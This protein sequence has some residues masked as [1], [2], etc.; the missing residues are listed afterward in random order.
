M[1]SQI[2][3][4]GRR[5]MLSCNGRITSGYCAGTVRVANADDRCVRHARRLRCLGMRSYS[6]A[7]WRDCLLSRWYSFQVLELALFA[8]ARC[9]VHT[10]AE[11]TSL[12]PTCLSPCSG[13]ERRQRS[14]CELAAL[15]PS[16]SIRALPKHSRSSCRS[17][18]TSLLLTQATATCSCS[19][20]KDAPYI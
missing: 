2:E 9:A 14:S 11:R 15:F 8:R 17:L 19:S 5:S 4:T 1:V 10:E 12:L 3:Q 7:R 6:C 18:R 16:R 20:N 13:I